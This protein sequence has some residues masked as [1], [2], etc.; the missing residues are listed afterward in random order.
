MTKDEEIWYLKSV[1]RR[2][3]YKDALRL[4]V[5][6]KYEGGQSAES[7]GSEYRIWTRT[8]Y[9]WLSKYGYEAKKGR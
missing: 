6:R 4:E 7:L 3:D 1:I 2:M 8:I 5:C 9:K